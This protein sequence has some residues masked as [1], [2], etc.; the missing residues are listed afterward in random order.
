MPE[1]V[2]VRVLESGRVLFRIDGC[3]FFLSH[4]EAM[5]LGRI[6]LDAGEMAA[7]RDERA[8]AEYV[9]QRKGGDR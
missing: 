9:R 4:E 1:V 6:L 3:S 5:R 8:R 2:E 7:E